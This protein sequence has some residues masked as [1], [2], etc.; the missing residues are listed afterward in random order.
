LSPI[1]RQHPAAMDPEAIVRLET[2][3]KALPEELSDI[4][5][6]FYLLEQNPQQIHRETGMSESALHD[7]RASL[8]LRFQ[9]AARAQ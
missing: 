3:W 2:L 4:L 7:L 1:I 5:R 6:R 9:A 8:R